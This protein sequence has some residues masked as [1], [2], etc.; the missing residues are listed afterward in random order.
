MHIPDGFLDAK[1][2]VV[3]TGLAAV[4]V[5]AAV[6]QARTQLPPSKV[7]LLGVT[8]AFVFAAQMVNFPIAGGTSGHLIGGVLAGVLLGPSGAVLVM[9]SVLTLQCLL[10]ADGG[11]LALGANIFNMG[12]VGGVGGYYVYRALSR[13]FGAR[14]KFL[15]VAVAAWCG[16]VMSAVATAGELSLSGVVPWSVGVLA[17]AGVH[18]VMGVGE[19]LITTLVVLAIDR[20]RPEILADG[21]AGLPLRGTGETVAFGLVIS[22]GLGIFVSPIASTWPDGLEKV[23]GAL[24]FLERAVKT[25]LAPAPI[26]DYALPGIASPGWAT[27]LAGGV[28]TTVV[29]LAV[30]VIARLIVPRRPSSRD[31]S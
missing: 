3:T 1:T 6:R 15:A 7:P 19:A 18:M 20:T 5:T 9:T 28:G 16:T 27:A 24:G 13:A 8:A 14:A 22:L 17:M 31:A 21:P 11:L 12:I 23:A 26:P 2:L 4:G 30:L 25:P 29:F 10:F